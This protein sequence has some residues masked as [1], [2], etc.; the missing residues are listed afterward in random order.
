MS[1]HLRPN[2]FRRAV[3]LILAII[4]SI[5]GN[6]PMAWAQS[7]DFAPPRPE[8]S[9]KIQSSLWDL[10]AMGQAP[11]PTGLATQDTV[12]VTL[13]PHLGQGSASIDTS[14]MA[15]LGVRV[16]ARSK[17]LMRVSAPAP[18]LLALSE[19]PGV[20]FVRKPIRPHAREETWSEGGWLIKA[21]ENL[22]EGFTG[23]GVK[24]A[25]V[26][27]G[28]GGANELAG[29]MPART[30]YR[31]YTGE[32][33]YADENVHGTAC[34]EIVHDM[35][36]GAELL[37]LKVGDLTDLENAKDLCIRQGIDIVSHS[38]AWLQTGIGDGKGMA[39]DIVNDAANNGILW[40]TAAGNSA[41]SHYYQFWADSDDDGWH[42]FGGED[43]TL[44]FEAE[45]GTGI[46][47][48]LTWNDWP[49]TRDNY[50]FHLYYSD[51]SSGDLEPVAESTD[52]QNGS[53]D[54]D[55]TEW[56]EYEAERSGRYHIAVS[57]AEEARARRIKI[58]A[59][60]DTVELDFEYS[61][62]ENSIETPADARGAMSVGAVYHGEYGRGT[63][64]DYSSRG[65]TTDGRIKPELVAPAGVSTVSYGASPY[66]GT[67][68]ATP[69]VAGAA[70]LIKGANPSYSRTELWNALI[71]ATVDVDARGRDNNTGYGKLVLPIMQASAP[72]RITSVS[73]GRVRY[74][75]VLTLRGTGFGA[76][77]GT[78]RVI[79]YEG[80]EPRSYQYVSWSDTQIRVR[81]PTGSRTGNLQVVTARGNDTARL[82][83]T[84]PWVRTV[85]PR[86]GRANTYVT[87]TGG[88]FGSSRGSSF[89]RIGT[90]GVSSFSTWS[91]S[92]I[93]FRIPVN[94]RPG[95]VSV[96]TPEGTSNT[97][98][99]EVTSPYLS[100]VSP[101]RV[102]PGDR[103]TLTGANFRTTRGSGYVL[104]TPNVRPDSGDYVTWTDR[105]IVVEVPS[106]AESGNVKV[107]T[108]RGSSGTRWIEV[109]GEALESLPSRGIFGYDPP[110]VTSNPKAVM[111]GFEGIGEDVVMTWTAKNEAAVDILVN[112]QS[113][114]SL[115]AGDDCDWR[116]WWTILDHPD[117]D[118]G[119]NVIEF[120]N[121]TNQYRTSSF[122]RWQ[123]KDVRLW[124]PF[125]AKRV[126]GATYL[127]PS[128]TILETGLGEPFPTPFNSEVTVP[129]ATAAPGPVRL[130][131]YNLMGQRIR[132]LHDGWTE[133]GPHQAHWDGRADSGAEA[134]TGLYWAV[135]RTEG[136]A[137]SAKLVLIR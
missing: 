123:L 63:V 124:K 93:R 71:A 70:A 99:L 60:T 49:Q 136:F 15:A 10:A 134:A 47:I 42:N 11:K 26:D 19:L 104:F 4:P 44:S 130:S 65:P 85:S 3:I 54:S 107:V 28:F 29:D 22:Q 16:L 76:A 78:S 113:Y 135:L 120:R 31:D 12:V 53:E 100:R 114:G 67:S 58:W 75:Q 127:G 74:N 50:D 102:E 88:N 109:E 24:V 121:R 32:G 2:D 128:R 59:Y 68:A 25:V 48:Y 125:N 46:S 118:S 94:S 115:P 101:A 34:A 35:A 111:F 55:P 13:V 57:K 30:P 38:L 133:A 23:Q 91:D 112:G 9:A 110:A 14:S 83:V 61:S 89:V 98:F 137:Q 33:I 86:S 73:P 6:V 105:R 45:E 79:F 129:F 5:A 106:R 56:I 103:L 77:R 81:V 116:V 96:R 97:L 132:V 80:R 52:V 90:A 1:L 95:N 66:H 119:R 51:S 117:L 82:T 21:Y 87:V 39:C 92:R 72:P 69:H 131:V 8:G 62:A 36:Q 18:S 84:S 122:T 43:E 7:L 27:V 64:A 37:L 20:R 40:V 41:R 126:A 17:S 108:V